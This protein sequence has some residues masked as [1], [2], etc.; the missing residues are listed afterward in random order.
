MQFL[1]PPGARG[2][3]LSFF[4]FKSASVSPA[5]VLQAFQNCC[6]AYTDYIT[7]SITTAVAPRCRKRSCGCS[8]LDFLIF[9]ARAGFSRSR[10]AFHKRASTWGFYILSPFVSASLKPRQIIIY[11]RVYPG[12]V[13]PLQSCGIVLTAFV[14]R[15]LARCLCRREKTLL[16]RLSASRSRS[17]SC[18]CVCE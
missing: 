8:D 6:I 10:A 12:D 2:I 11:M 16:C 5:S 1:T 7:N 18:V 14:R 15:I 17:S 4:F 3:F 9:Q 13:G